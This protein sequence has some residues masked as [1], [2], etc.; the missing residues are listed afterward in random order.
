MTQPPFKDGD[1]IRPR[2]AADGG[3]HM[4]CCDCGLVHR[5]DFTL[6]LNDVEIDPA[7]VRLELRVYRDEERTLAARGG[8]PDW[9]VNPVSEARRDRE[10]K[11]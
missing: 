3:Y 7:K 2:M 6:N 11:S 8:S 1:L 5:L 9:W 4:Q 10:R